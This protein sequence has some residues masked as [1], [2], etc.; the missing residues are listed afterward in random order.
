MVF[1]LKQKRTYEI[2]VSLVGTEMCIGASPKPGTKAEPKAKA[3]AKAAPGAGQKIVGM[4][5][6]NP[7]SQ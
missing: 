4:K 5:G 2:R 6:G 1:F 7:K 3:K